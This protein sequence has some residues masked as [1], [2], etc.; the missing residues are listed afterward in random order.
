MIQYCLLDPK[1]PPPSRATDQS[2]GI[3]LFQPETVVLLPGEKGTI[4][5]GLKLK[6]PDNI[7]GILLLR[8]WAAKRYRV[9]LHT[10]VIGTALACL[11]ALALF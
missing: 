10:G 1:A 2:A 6:I 4:D 9:H 11:C 8:S 3:D 5:L 7:G